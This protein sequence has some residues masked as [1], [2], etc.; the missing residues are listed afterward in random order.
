MNETE[1]T[2]VPPQEIKP[3][4]LGINLAKQEM[5][6][7]QKNAFE[8]A[9]L[10]KI[11]A[12][13]LESLI[14][15]RKDLESQIMSD[16]EKGDKDSHPKEL[17][18]LFE[19]IMAE[20]VQEGHLLSIEDLKIILESVEKLK[21]IFDYNHSG[22]VAGI[23]FDLEYTESLDLGADKLEMP[24]A[25]ILPRRNQR[26]VTA[27]D[28]ATKPLVEATSYNENI[29][30]NELW[31]QA[32]NLYPEGAEYF[33]EEAFIKEEID[34]QYAFAFLKQRDVDLEIK[35]QH[36]IA[37]NQ[38]AGMVLSELNGNKGVI[39]EYERKQEGLIQYRKQRL[40]GV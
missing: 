11:K 34:L 39:K 29:N 38:P 37:N 35:R 19:H 14:K 24:D 4:A 1:F 22:H 10:A 15:F 3:E 26:F 31:K 20:S 25:K 28:R 7:E 5:H 33:L 6:E 2:Q 13:Y 27:V 17:R 36:L 8:Q 32:A 9:L 40:P 21:P 30:F 23:K 18:T 12:E 16:L